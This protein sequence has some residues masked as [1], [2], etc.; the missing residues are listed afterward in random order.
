MPQQNGVVEQRNRTLVEVARTMLIFSKSSEFLRAEA[1]S[2]AYFTQNRSLVNTRYNKT[3]YDLIKDRKP[4]VQYFHVFGSLCYPTNDRDNLGK[5]KPK[6]DIGIFISYFESSRGFRIYNHIT[7]KIME[8]IHVKFDELTTM[9][10]ECN[11]SGPSLNCSNFKDSSE[12]I[13]EIPSKEDFDN[14]FGPLY[15]EYYATR[16]PK[17]SDNYAANTLNNGDTPSS[18][19]IIVEEHEAP[20]VVSSSKE[21][22][23]NE[24]I[25]PISDDN[26][27]ELVQENVAELDRNAFINPFCTPE[28]MNN[29][30]IEQVIGDLS[31]PAMT[32]S[33]LYTD[34]EICMYVLTIS[35]TSPINIKAAILDHSWIESMQDE[36]NWFK[37]LDV[38]ELVERHVDR[39]IITVKRLCQLLKTRLFRII[40][41]NRFAKLKKDNIEMSMIG[42]MK[43]FLRLQIHQS[44]RGIFISQSQ[45]TLEIL[46]KHGMDG[47]DSIPMASA[48]IDADLQS[49]L[50]DQTKY[51]SMIGGLMHLTTSRPDIAFAT[52]VCVHY[53]ACPIEK[54]LKEVKQIIRYL[55]YT[56]NNGLWYLKDSK[57]EL[58]A[59]SDADHARC[60]DDCKI[61]YGGIQFL[62]D[63]LEN[64]DVRV[65]RHGNWTSK[66]MKLCCQVITTM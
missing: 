46:H 35:T 30:P 37:R 20:Q 47:C 11:I 32:R 5:M 49:I 25:T 41:S 63:K 17:V 12:D 24:P 3:P 10:S 34:V 21:P 16:T 28:W 61:T 45:Y 31:K 23:A 56:I 65:E 1:I 9:A 58:I 18:S 8:T 15:E 64:M 52:F 55:K 14:L 26:T 57:Y 42:E 43:F 53:Q 59:Y 7:R 19:S 48:R 40:F 33:R 39:N 13:T 54:H 6:A 66:R 27:N 38:W 50:T 29:H 60:H 2:T 4:I 62:G 36:L 44:S 51:Q 22:I